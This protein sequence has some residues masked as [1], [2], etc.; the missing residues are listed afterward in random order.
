[1][2]NILKD[3]TVEEIVEELLKEAI[4]DFDMAKAS[5]GREVSF[6]YWFR[7]ELTHTLQ[8]E[9]QRCEEMVEEVK[10]NITDTK[11]FDVLLNQREQCD[12]DGIMV[13]VSRQALDEIL[14]AL[15]HPNNTK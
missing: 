4:N 6:S 9:R 2:Q 7:D 15:T 8:A 1:M 3:R 12:E 10:K 5:A 14:E 11:A 13:R